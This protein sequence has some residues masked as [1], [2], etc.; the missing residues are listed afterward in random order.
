MADINEFIKQL[1]PGLQTQ[2][3]STAP[4]GSNSGDVSQALDLLNMQFQPQV[5]TVGSS[6]QQL[7]KLLE[8]DTAA[9]QKYG[10]IADAKVSEIGDKLSQNLGLGVKATQD[11]FGNAASQVG[12]T[13]QNADKSMGDL[14]QGITSNL[15]NVA[16]GLGQSQSLSGYGNPVDRL[17]AQSI[18]NRTQAQASGAAA[19]SNLQGLGGSLAGIA[20][21]RVGSSQQEYAGLRAQIAK[22]VQGNIAELQ[23]KTNQGI[24]ELLDNLTDIASTYGA[25]FRT[26]LQQISQTRNA[27]ERDA[28]NDEIA[29]MLKMM[30]LQKGQQD[31]QMDAQRYQQNAE[32]HPLDMLSK[33]LGID[34]ANLGMQE[35][36]L[37]ILKKQGD[38]SGAATKGEYSGRKGLDQWLQ[39]T[40]QRG[41]FGGS[42]RRLI[43]QGPDLASQAGAENLTNVDPYD[44][45]RQYVEQNRQG[46][47]IQFPTPAGS[48]SKTKRDYQ[49]DVN[50][51]LTALDIYFNKYGS[52][53]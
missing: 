38:L 32:M 27:A 22:D 47:T 9:S 15:S 39:D 25:N 5:T 30:Q 11:I 4:A 42:V 10:Q 1:L 45:V 34:R 50:D 16:Q 48:P 3:K 31:M 19:Q 8:Q 26:T 36:G 21:Q 29:N 43:G 52:V 24:Q 20:Q 12:Q 46:N 2:A 41:Y 7:Q 6:I 14:T 13:Y 28:A 37:D 51:V 40:G 23:V 17:N 53:K 33:S 44:A 49:F 35:A 18:A